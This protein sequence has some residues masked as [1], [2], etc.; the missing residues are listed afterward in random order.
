MG[1]FLFGALGVF[2]SGSLL[3][4]FVFWQILSL[5]M[6]LL[7]GVAS[8]NAGTVRA[9]SKTYLV[10]LLADGCFLFGLGILANKMGNTTI[11]DLVRWLG[12]LAS[13]DLNLVHLQG[14]Q[15]MRAST[16]TLIG[17]CMLLAAGARLLQFPVRNGVD[18]PS[19]GGAAA[20]ALMQSVGGAA[21]A[22]FL[23]ARVFPI[24]TPTARMMLAVVGLAAMI[25]GSIW[26]AIGET[27]DEVLEFNTVGQFGFVFLA[28][29]IGG[30]LGGLFLLITHAFS[31]AL[32]FMSG[33]VASRE[34]GDRVDLQPLGGLLNRIPL[35][36]TAF[37][38]GALAMIGVPLVSGY[39]SHDL[40]LNNIAAY[41]G[42]LL[43]NH[44]SIMAR[45]IV[46]LCIAGIVLT[47]FSMM[48]CWMLIFW[49]NSR[50]PR[51]ENPPELARELGIVWMPM[52][53][54]AMIAIVGGSPLMEIKDRLGLAITETDT[55]CYVVGVPT[56][57]G[58]ISLLQM[59]PVD[60][61]TTSA[62]DLDDALSSTRPLEEMGHQRVHAA[63]SWGMLLG[64][65]LAA[66]L[67]VRGFA[68][69]TTLLRLAPPRWA[70]WLP[71]NRILHG[72]HFWGTIS[73]LGIGLGRRILRLDRRI[74]GLSDLA[75]RVFGGGRAL[76]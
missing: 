1:F 47:A 30:W 14:E 21:A 76:K 51:A 6:F 65:A 72:V 61:D 48:R 58:S 42:A 70:K 10:Q 73:R 55:F 13:G 39:Y 74:E 27:I 11:S 7:S 25:L 19:P 64:A 23:L 35:S 69:T 3:Q 63:A 54:L 49:G 75:A 38:I 53:M 59:W 33:G 50:R 2:L 32:L 34:A 56:T 62:E 52:A 24:L 20:S 8:G 71:P 46:A 36:A 28:L 31:K 18:D 12:P 68:V 60:T 57:R 4:I 37:G 26:S 16:Q 15:V 66:L 5:G 43:Q 44:H 29:A 45:T 41:A 9:A 67:Y 17:F 40:L 22:A